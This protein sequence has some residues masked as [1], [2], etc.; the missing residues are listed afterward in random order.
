M[1]HMTHPIPKRITP[2]KAGQR[3][4]CNPAS[5]ASCPDVPWSRM[6]SCNVSEITIM[7]NPAPHTRIPMLDGFGIFIATGGVG[8]VDIGDDIVK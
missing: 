4:L 7:R 5:M 3:D 2:V 6:N 8:G 1:S